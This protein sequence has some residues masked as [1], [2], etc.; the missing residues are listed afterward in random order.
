MYLTIFLNTAFFG[1]NFDRFSKQIME[2]KVV[3]MN[4]CL[5]MQSFYFI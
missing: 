4:K 3:E 1:P 2:L 5:I